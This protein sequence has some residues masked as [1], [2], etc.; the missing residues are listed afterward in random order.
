MR[1]G[2]E[3]DLAVKR[4]FCSTS[5]NGCPDYIRSPFS[6]L[7]MTL[8]H[9]KTKK[10]RIHLIFIGII[11]IAGVFAMSPS[12]Q[13]ATGINK[14]INFQG[15]VVNA[16]GTNVANGSYDFVFKIYSVDTG[17]T[18]I[19][20]ETRTGSNQVTV[21]DGV[22]QVNLG[23]VTAL[24]GS[25]DFNT[26]N[27]YLGVEF[28]NDGEMS[29]RVRFTAAPY[30]FN[31]DKVR[32]LTVTDTT[33]T[34]TIANGK[35]VSFA[36]AFSTAGAFS[37]TL[38]A[39]GPTNVTLPTTGTLA[40]IAGV[41]TLTNK[42]IGS[43]GLT[44][45]GAATD[46]T[47]VSGESLVITAAGAGTV[48]IQ[49]AA[50][51]DSLTTDTGGVSIAA[52]QSYTGD[53]AVTLSSGG[54]AGLT[55]DSASGV[56]TVATGDYLSLSKSGVSGAAAGY[57]WYD[58]S[59]NK[60]KINENGSTKVICNTTDA[61]CGSGGGTTWNTIGDATATGAVAMSD[62]AQTLDWNTNNVSALAMDG[63]TV[64]L[65]NDAATDILTQRAFVVANQDDSASTG[66]T[67][68]ILQVVNRDVNETVG[69]GLLIENTG[70]GTMTNA[71]QITETAG[72]ITNG[73]VFSGALSVGIDTASNIIV[74]IGDSGTDFSA[75][76]G[77]TLADALAVSSGGI[78]ATGTVAFTNI[79]AGVSLQVN[80]ESSDA[81]PFVVDADGNVGIGTATPARILDI[82]SAA[83]APQLRLSKDLTYYSEFM[84][85]SVGDL[86]MAAVG[87]D[88]RALSENVWVCDNDA[89]PALTLTG[90]GNIF[91]ENVLK[92]GNGVYIKNDS[93]TELAVYDNDDNA[94]LVFDEL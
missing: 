3:S 53:G 79:G 26:D 83:S 13:A 80:D 70:A 81:T 47:T 25:I 82:V 37:L 85:D 52:N 19:W 67:E 15:R 58:S 30:A 90:E 61:G 32:G 29:P 43:T 69:T 65:T 38:T 42:T 55:I 88:I 8:Q 57:I 11:A 20:T 40:T 86:Q 64:S 33:G 44:F 21:T 51:V 71:I 22:F 24:P 60:F 17:G 35:T 12:V 68:T 93:S 18:A 14:Q 72:A 84:V 56:V 87:G 46:I 54:T 16:D 73:I 92:F 1:E 4:F 75:T 6:F 50:T 76:G 36:D 27:I 10:S 41:E 31:A 2:K 94:M 34:L 91:V 74:N 28:N 49:D 62:W 39:T 89:C 45:S 23:S 59:D 9:K 66:T 48:D 77:L 7:D 63:L 78:T 5:P